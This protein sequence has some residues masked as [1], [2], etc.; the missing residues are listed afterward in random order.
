MLLS[1]KR[2]DSNGIVFTLKIMKNVIGKGEKVHLFK[3][4]RIGFLNPLIKNRKTKRDS[5]KESMETL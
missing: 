4:W 5:P 1:L 3:G 2:K